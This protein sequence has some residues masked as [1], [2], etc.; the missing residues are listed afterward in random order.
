M[1]RAADPEL[2][3]LARRFP[4]WEI[5]RGISG[6]WFARPSGA[7]VAPLTGETADELASEIERAER[8]G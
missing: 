5:W 1:S 7:Y 3:G 6:A 8:G 4:R 2:A